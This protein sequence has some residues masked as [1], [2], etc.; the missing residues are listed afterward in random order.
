[1]HKGVSAPLSFQGP[2]EVKQANIDTHHW[3]S[4]LDEEHTFVCSNCD[5]RYGSHSS[6]WPCGYPVPRTND[7]Q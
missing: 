5:C 3:V 1:M 2:K 6:E 4:G 7:I